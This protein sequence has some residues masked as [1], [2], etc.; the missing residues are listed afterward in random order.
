MEKVRHHWVPQ[1]LPN[2]ITSTPVF[3]K[4]HP[5]RPTGSQP[6]MNTALLPRS[7]T[8]P[9]GVLKNLVPP[10]QSNLSAFLSSFEFANSVGH[11]SELNSTEPPSKKRKFCNTAPTAFRQNQRHGKQVSSGCH[12]AP[13]SEVRPS[14]C[15]SRN[16]AKHKPTGISI[17]GHRPISPTERESPFSSHAVSSRISSYVT[18]PNTTAPT[19]PKFSFEEL[20][21][22]CT[23]TPCSA[24]L[25]I[26]SQLKS[27][28]EQ[29]KL[30]PTLVTYPPLTHLPAQTWKE[31][32][33]KRPVHKNSN[34]INANI[35]LT[36]PYSP[37][38]HS[39][40]WRQ[41]AIPEALS[42]TLL[43]TFCSSKEDVSSP[44]S[45]LNRGLE[46]FF[47]MGHSKQCWCSKHRA[48][49]SYVSDSIEDASLL[50]P[51]AIGADPTNTLLRE[52]EQDLETRFSHL[53]GSS[54]MESQTE[55][56]T[57]V[58]TDSKIH[59]RG[60]DTE[61]EDW[62]S[63]DEITHQDIA[64]EEEWAFISRG[65]PHHEAQ[66]IP[67]SGSASETSV[68][69]SLPPTPPLTPPLTPAIPLHSTLHTVSSDED[70]ADTPDPWMMNAV[71]FSQSRDCAMCLR[72]ECVCNSANVSAVEWPSLQE[73]MEM[74]QRGRACR[75]WDTHSWG[76]W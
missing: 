51:L 74:R 62:H 58:G 9:D 27:A 34:L 44:S 36:D 37:V 14:S 45:D 21:P 30:P 22:T 42:S 7:G 5:Q 50:S 2:V 64:G 8:R 20:S 43:P 59:S 68:L 26:T 49:A 66:F 46:D 17:L 15:L 25:S 3:S 61:F 33:K 76:Q 24:A 13:P 10:P 16:A 63:L 73:S 1:F 23:S 52:Q 72:C 32:P 19:L 75:M 38:S 57:E 39:Q 47:D 11:G 54:A 29:A 65:A 41:I 18:T 56:G 71:C 67:F 48:V 12:D 28:S 55:T 35:S 6:P 69:I 31:A 4:A 70:D 40:S 53:P 60:S